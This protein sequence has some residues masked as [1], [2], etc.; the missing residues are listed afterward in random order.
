MG[1]MGVFEGDVSDF[2][3]WRSVGFA[4]KRLLW[5]V[6]GVLLKVT[7]ANRRPLPVWT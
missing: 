1:D 3:F 2:R 6:F 4:L 5:S 7:F